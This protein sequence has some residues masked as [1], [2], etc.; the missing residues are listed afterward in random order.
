MTLGASRVSC[1]TVVGMERRQPV[2]LTT[3]GWTLPPGWT[4]YT[5][6][7]YDDQPAELEG[8][9]DVQGCI[10]TITSDIHA[11]ISGPAEVRIRD[12]LAPDAMDRSIQRDGITLDILRAVPLGDARKVLAE[13][14]P[15]LRAAFSPDDAPKP[16]PARVESPHD[17]T[18]VAAEYVRLVNAGERRPIHVMSEVSGVS[19]NTM[20]AR[21]RRARD[22]GLLLQIG[23][24]AKLRAEL[25]PQAIAELNESEET[26]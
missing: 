6:A 15:R 2:N 9:Y 25:T 21:V 16:L 10:V 1:A 19:R 4:L 5:A 14:L 23:T 22:M 3:H 20:S 17:Y 13:W 26:N 8:V 11:P 7:R 12:L 24:G 18:L